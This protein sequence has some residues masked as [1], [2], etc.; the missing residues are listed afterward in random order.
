MGE[1]R[2]DY[3]PNSGATPF[4]QL[5]ILPVY[6]KMVFTLPKFFFCKKFTKYLYLAALSDAML[7]GPIIFVSHLPSQE[8]LTEGK[9]LY[10]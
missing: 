9:A 1:G 2:I 6:K 4:G 5:A 8:T 10:R 7:K 3:N